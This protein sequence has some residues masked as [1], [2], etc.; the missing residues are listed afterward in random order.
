MTTGEHASG[1]LRGE[2]ITEGRPVC[3]ACGQCDLHEDSPHEFADGLIDQL[4]CQDCGARH[5]V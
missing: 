2:G 5:R 4:I 3:P 1:A